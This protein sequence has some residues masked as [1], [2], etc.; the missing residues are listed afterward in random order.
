MR[1]ISIPRFDRKGP[2]CRAPAKKIP[3]RVNMVDA[4]EKLC[5]F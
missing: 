1:G 4:R 5:G 2:A 3:A